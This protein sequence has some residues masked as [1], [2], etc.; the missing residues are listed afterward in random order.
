VLWL[1]PIELWSNQTS[2]GTVA[3]VLA[4]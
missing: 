3:G 2:S 1:A 4:V